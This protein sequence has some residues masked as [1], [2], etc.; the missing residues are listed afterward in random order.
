MARWTARILGIIVALLAIVGLFIEG[1]HL[2]G[3]ANVDLT[4]DIVRIVIAAALLWV[5][6]GRTS[7]TA[8]T[9][10]LAV[11]GVMYVLMAL[12][13]FADATLFGLLPTG[14]TGFD[15]GFHLVAGIIA[16]IAAFVPAR[17]RA[18]TPSTARA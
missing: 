11:V 14:F 3:I 5:G 12:L 15:I 8:L 17:E 2:L 13:A 7:R 16:L 18:A 4:L 6:F 1:E 9:V 10:V